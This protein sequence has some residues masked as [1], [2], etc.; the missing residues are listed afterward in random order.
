LPSWRQLD[1][2]PC[3]HRARLWWA[4][5]SFLHLQPQLYKPADGFGLSQLALC[6]ISGGFRL[7]SLCR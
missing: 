3:A 6:P 5:L 7:G 4:F 2:M 1:E